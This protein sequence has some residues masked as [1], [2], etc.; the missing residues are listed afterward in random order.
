MT[1]F[2]RILS[3]CFGI[4]YLLP[5]GQGT[6]AAFAALFLAPYFLHTAL[7]WQLGIVIIGC[8]VGIFVSS[9]AEKEFEKKDDHRIVIDEFVSIFITFL[10][11]A[12][13]ISW[14]WLFAGFLLNRLF[15][16]WKPTPIFALQ[17]LPGGWGIMADD[18]IAGIYS[19][20]ALRAIM[21]FL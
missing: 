2:S 15:D 20:I 16:I 13:G 9:R 21:F 11:F 10:G 7:G 1:T 14:Y 3:T 8:V 17:R 5:I 18:V 12:V 6:L 4:G 19:N